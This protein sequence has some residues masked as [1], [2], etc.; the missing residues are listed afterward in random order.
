[1]LESDVSN[2]EVRLE[3]IKLIEKK[4]HPLNNRAVN[5]GTA[6]RKLLAGAK[7]AWAQGAAAT[8]ALE[9]LVCIENHVAAI[10]QLCHEAEAIVAA[11]RDTR[12]SFTVAVHCIDAS[13]ETT[14]T[15]TM[16]KSDTVSAL[17]D[18]IM[19]LTGLLADEQQL[20]LW[21]NSGGGA[22]L[23]DDQ[24]SLSEISLQSGSTV[25]HCSQIHP[26]TGNVTM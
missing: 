4:I 25:I 15:V 7:P 9:H 8:T 18:E 22:F 20:E 16:Q 1:M 19:E 17:K 26:P 5:L 3:N 13:E 14:V 2:G 6:L 12:V 11:I 10:Q 24:A 21:S 23:T